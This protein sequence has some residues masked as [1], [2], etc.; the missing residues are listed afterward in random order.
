MIGIVPMVV[1]RWRRSDVNLWH[2]GRTYTT[3]D[4]PNSS[5]RCSWIIAVT[6][7]GAALKL[8]LQAY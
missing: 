5:E 6:A 1:L 3:V 7:L 8:R 4:G 2:S